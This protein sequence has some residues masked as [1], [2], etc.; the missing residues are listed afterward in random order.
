[1]WCR[2]FGAATVFISVP[3]TVIIGLFIS[4]ALNGI[5]KGQTVFQTIFFL[6][7]VTNSIALGL[8]FSV[9]FGS[10]NGLINSLIVALGGERISWVTAFGGMDQYVK[11]R[12][13]GV[14]Q[15]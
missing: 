12:A 2:S 5:K 6:P 15:G 4:V 11:C 9:L 3:L 14:Y 1:M 10:R 7:Y 8:V 13:G